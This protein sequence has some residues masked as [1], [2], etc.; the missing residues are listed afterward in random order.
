MPGEIIVKFKRGVADSLEQQ[1]VEATDVEDLRLSASL[2]GI[3]YQQD[4]TGPIA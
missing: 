1:L 4:F 3:S 2:D